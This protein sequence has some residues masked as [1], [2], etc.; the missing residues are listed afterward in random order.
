[1]HGALGDAPGA[2]ED[3]HDGVGRDR[4][5]RSGF[6]DDADGLALAN[7]DIDVLDRADGTAPRRE[8]HGQVA[9]LEKG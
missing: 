3:A 8:L 7:A 5:S 1:M 9:D 6:A 2:V 4:L